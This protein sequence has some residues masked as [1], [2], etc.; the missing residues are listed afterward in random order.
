MSALQ[1]NRVNE[2]NILKQNKGRFFFILRGYKFFGL[3]VCTLI[4]LWQFAIRTQIVGKELVIAGVLYMALLYRLEKSTGGYYIGKLRISSVVFS[5]WISLVFTQLVFIVIA[6]YLNRE[7]IP[8]SHLL[9]ITLAAVFTLIWGIAGDRLARALSPPYKT[10]IVYDEDNIWD[11]KRM[12]YPFPKQLEII[13]SYDISHGFKNIIEEAEKA[14][15][16]Y[17]YRIPSDMR[18]DF[19]KFATAKDLFVYVEPR[20]GDLILNSY[21]KSQLFQPPVLRYNSR[22]TLSTYQIEKRFLDVVLSCIG[23]LVTSPLLLVISLLIK[24]EDRGPVFY[25]QIRLTQDRKEFNIIKF[26]SMS[27]NAE[28]DGIARLSTRNDPRVTHV[29][30]WIRKTRIDELPQLINVLKGEMSIVGP[31]P[32]RPD[33]AQQYEQELP[34]F[35]LRLLAKAGITGY[36]QVYGKYNT[37]PYEKL[38]MDLMYILNQ[39]LWEDIKLI[40][41]TPRLFLVGK[42]STDGIEEGQVTAM[43]DYE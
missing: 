9:S 31:R 41:L 2:T 14:D 33:I 25:K 35:A 37:P 7:F 34:E 1:K 4:F 15:V 5:K 43:K 11:K 38:Q 18:N 13:A 40:L 12:K 26:R 22:D 21:R 6:Q 23:L 39:S 3:V 28:A 27:V 36:A 29:G 42:G 17:L 10:I 20:L 16:L 24:V 32:E 30:K 8:G 19:L